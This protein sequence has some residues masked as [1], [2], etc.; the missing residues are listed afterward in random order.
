MVGGEL[1]LTPVEY[2]F[3]SL[4]AQSTV[5]DHGNRSIDLIFDDRGRAGEFRLS[6]IRV[7]RHSADSR[8]RWV[9]SVL[10]RQVKKRLPGLQYKPSRHSPELLE[11]QDDLPVY[12]LPG[13]SDI[14]VVL[15]PGYSIRISKNYLFD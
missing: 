2:E 6:S 14:I 12:T 8:V 9:R 5:V 10:L 3:I 15:E 4:V 1:S 13:A 11:E 7:T